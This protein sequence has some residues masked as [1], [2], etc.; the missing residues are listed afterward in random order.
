MNVR[1]EIGWQSTIA[2][3]KE[4]RRLQTLLLRGSVQSELLAGDKELRAA[5]SGAW[6]VKDQMSVTK[7]CYDEEKIVLY[8]VASESD[9]DYCAFV[10]DPTTG[11][12]KGLLCSFSLPK[13][14]SGLSPVK[15]GD[16]STSPPLFSMLVVLGPPGLED[17][18]HRAISSYGII[19][20]LDQSQ[21][22]QPRLV[23]NLLHTVFSMASFSCTIQPRT[24]CM[25]IA[26]TQ[27]R[28]KMPL[29]CALGQL[30][31][32]ESIIK[33]AMPSRLLS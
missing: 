25:N 2:D 30:Y 32:L 27:K 12:K 26:S 31:P 22:T 24:C 18:V 14:I 29:L 10:Y 8:G 4:M 7:M 9:Y 3:C 16:S 6:D 17:H 11:E 15:V 5:L 20:I 19:L 1:K 21:P 28:S 23:L 33:M 13:T